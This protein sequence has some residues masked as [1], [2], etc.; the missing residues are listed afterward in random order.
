MQIEERPTHKLDV[1]KRIPAI[2]TFPTMYS[3]SNMCNMNGKHEKQTCTTLR[4]SRPSHG[5]LKL[6]G[7]RAGTPKLASTLHKQVHEGDRP[8][9]PLTCRSFVGFRWI[10]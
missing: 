6:L 4:T 1:N 7:K 9:L 2:T 3:M 8:S 5:C 10:R